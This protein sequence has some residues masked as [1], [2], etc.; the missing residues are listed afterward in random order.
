MI[1]QIDV[2]L[3]AMKKYILFKA[4]RGIYNIIREEGLKRERVRVFAG[5]AGGPKWFVSVGLDKALMRT[6]FLTR[7][8]GNKTLL[9]GSSAGAWRCL[10]MACKDPLDAYEKLR[11]AYSRNIFTSRDT[12]DTIS[13]KL[14][15]NV[16]SFISAD[17]VDS[18]INNEKFDVA[19]HVV[20]SKGMAASSNHRVEGLALVCAA[21]MNVISPQLMKIFYERVIFYSGTPAPQ[22]LGD[23]FDGMARRL[24]RDNLISAALATGS[25]PYIISGV[26]DV[27]GV[28]R[29]VL[30][31]G[32]LLDYQLNQDYHPGEDGLTLFF[33]YQR[34]ITPGW[35]DKRL[36]WRKPSEATVNRVLQIYPGQ[37]F[38]ELLPDKRIP[39]RS[40][41]IT[42]ADN[43]S[44]RIKRWDRVSTI[45]EALA[46]YFFEVVESGKIK[47]LVQPL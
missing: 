36:S 12:P 21:T 4:G 44:E 15:G 23:R 35:F 2:I 24:D 3:R 5:P 39:D 37:D 20:R 42:F 6:G 30:R 31:D 32:G 19:V 46:D 34:R 40:D 28:G 1:G 38:V 14:L 11:I 33:H 13:A 9:A 27:S 17:D 10:A 18:I 16:E 29:G 7:A 45:S 43:P 25:L 8:D 47:E 26:D 22:F 41:F